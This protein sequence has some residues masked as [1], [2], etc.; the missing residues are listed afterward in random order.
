M[1]ILDPGVLRIM[2]Q[3][4]RTVIPREGLGGPRFLEVPIRV[5]SGWGGGARG[6]C[7]LCENKA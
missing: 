1:S 7:V 3:L 4:P 5:W 6:G 2:Y